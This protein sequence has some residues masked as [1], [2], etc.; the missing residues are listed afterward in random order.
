MEKRNSTGFS[1]LRFGA[2]PRE[3]GPGGLFGVLGHAGGREIAAC[4]AQFAELRVI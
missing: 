3:N 2:D 4:G 1:A